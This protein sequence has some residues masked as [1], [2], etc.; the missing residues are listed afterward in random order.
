MILDVPTSMRSCYMIKDLLSRY[1]EVDRAPT[2]ITGKCIIHMYPCRDTIVDHDDSSCG[3]ID[4]LIFDMHIYDTSDMTVYKSNNYHDR[5]ELNVPAHV[6]VFKDLSTMI[7]VL[8]GCQF[9][10]GQSVEVNELY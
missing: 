2:I 9:R 1:T 6:Q 5:I 3:F 7:V 4:S 10:Y 8:D